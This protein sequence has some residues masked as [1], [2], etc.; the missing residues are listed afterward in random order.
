MMPFT[1]LY[2][3]LVF[4]FDSV[5]LGYIKKYTSFRLVI[6]FFYETKV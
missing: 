2:G 1:S 6:I 5:H 3:I 4:M